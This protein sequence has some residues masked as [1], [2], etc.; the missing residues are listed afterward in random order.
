MRICPGPAYF[1]LSLCF[2][3]SASW[4]SPGEHLSWAL[5]L[6]CLYLATGTKMVEPAYYGLKLMTELILPPFKWFSLTFCHCDG[7]WP[8]LKD[9]AARDFIASRTSSVAGRQIFPDARTLEK[10][11]S[12]ENQVPGL[13]KSSSA[14]I[15][16]VLFLV[17]L[18]RHCILSQS[19]LLSLFYYLIIV[20]SPWNSNDSQT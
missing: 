9:T 7:Y 18:E 6:L 10:A 15:L 11:A 1:V 14:E 3:L 20:S 12:D 5:L 2:F 4:L 8:S 19:M 17:V 16:P 13:P